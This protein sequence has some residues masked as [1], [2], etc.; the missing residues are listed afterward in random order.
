MGKCPKAR[1]KPGARPVCESGHWHD[2]VRFEPVI[3]G[4]GCIALRIV[5]VDGQFF[6]SLDCACRGEH[7][8]ARHSIMDRGIAQVGG[9][10]VVVH[11]AVTQRERGF[12]GSPAEGAPVEDT[13]LEIQVLI[14]ERLEE[15][16]NR[17]NFDDLAGLNSANGNHAPALLRVDEFQMPNAMPIARFHI[18]RPRSSEATGRQL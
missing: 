9:I 4:R 11:A 2:P 6:A 3:P 8:C 12:S 7:E 17:C 15:L 1:P 5:V 14:C 13:A 18:A 16:N 10:S